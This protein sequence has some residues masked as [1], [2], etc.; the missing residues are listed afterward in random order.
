VSLID[1][2]PAVRDQGQRETCVA[3][4]SAAFLEF[5]LAGG[6]AKT[7]RRSEQF[8]YWA[9]KEVDGMPTQGGT[10]LAAARKVLKSRGVC[11]NA[12]WKYEPMPIGPTEGQGPPP[13]KA[14][15]E[16]KQAR[17][18]DAAEQAPAGDV[19]AIRGHLDEGRPVVVGVLTFS[20]WDFPTVADTGE[21]GL[22]LPLS[23]PDGGHAVCLVGYEPRP[24]APGGG[25]F[26]FR[27]SWGK[28]W[29][30]RSEHRA[31]YGTLFFEYVRQY[32]LEA[33]R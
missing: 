18:S 10:T 6:S 28:S 29:A 7:K 20:N 8:L 3:F 23:Q 4:A 26:L 33:Y 11:L 1:K 15:A 13:G 16:A 12:T 25:A 14:V 21:I 27:N 22:P 9:C 2:F 30:A 17:W 5:H 32:T 31:G 24:N 19:D